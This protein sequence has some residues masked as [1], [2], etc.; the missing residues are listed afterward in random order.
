MDWMVVEV[1][2]EWEGWFYSSGG[3]GGVILG[4]GRVDAC[5]WGTTTRPKPETDSNLNFRCH[6]NLICVS[7][8]QTAGNT[9]FDTNVN[10]VFWI[11]AIALYNNKIIYCGFYSMQTFRQ[12]R[13]LAHSQQIETLARLLI[14]LKRWIKIF[15]N[16]I[17]LQIQKKWWSSI[18]SW[19]PKGFKCHSQS[20]RDVLF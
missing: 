1:E 4:L 7:C 2:W 13:A 5:Q 19:G 11:A 18:K 14:L 8:R 20:E 10:I 16:I 9:I 6:K 17:L 3:S 15:Q 12:K